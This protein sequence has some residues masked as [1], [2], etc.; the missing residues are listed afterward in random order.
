M[1]TKR[2]ANKLFLIAAVVST[3]ALAQS[4]L[5][6]FRRAAT[7]D[8]S[9]SPAQNVF[10]DNAFADALNGERPADFSPKAVAANNSVAATSS[11]T[12]LDSAAGWSRFVSGVTLEDTIKQLKSQLAQ[13]IVQ[14]AQFSGGGNRDARRQF[15]LLSTLFTI[16]E[17]YDGDVRWKKDATAARE[18]FRNAAQTAKVGSIQA[19]NAAKNARADLVDLIGG[20][21]MPAI[22]ADPVSDW[23]LVADRS[24]LMQ[25]LEALLDDNLQPQTNDASSFKQNAATL[26]RNAEYMAALTVVLTLDDMEDGSDEDYQAFCRRIQQAAADIVKAV[27]LGNAA[28]ARKATGEISKSCSECHELYRG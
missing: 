2:V 18:K 16:I 6:R 21:A 22:A 24:L 1:K 8:W 7:P 17:Q 23:S 27:E 14:P 25:Q 12:P 15:V 11:A 13:S 28:D 5:V 3:A 26:R 9:K 10:F 20:N 4:G 19:F